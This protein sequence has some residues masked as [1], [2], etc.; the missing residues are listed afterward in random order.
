MTGAEQALAAELY[1]V[2]PDGGPVAVVRHRSG[3][4]MVGV[5]VAGKPWAEPLTGRRYARSTFQGLRHAGVLDGPPTFKRDKG[6][7]YVRIVPA[8]IQEP[9]T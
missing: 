1:A 2:A 4:F 9:T 7:T 6:V 3:A 8:R 5:R